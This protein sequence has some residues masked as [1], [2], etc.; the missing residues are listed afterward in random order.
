MKRLASIVF[1]AVSVS[2]FLCAVGLGGTTTHTAYIDVGQSTVIGFTESEYKNVND[3]LIQYEPTG[4]YGEQLDAGVVNGAL[5]AIMNADLLIVGGT[6]L[7]VYPA[8]GFLKYFGGDE[9]VLINRDATA[10]DGAA[11]LVIREPI[12]KVFE[13]IKL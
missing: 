4:E 2:S 7:T 13:R 6:S 9:L 12:A 11:S 3:K 1:L 8:A 5:H 10:F